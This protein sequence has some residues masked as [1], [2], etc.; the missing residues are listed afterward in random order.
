MNWRKT[1]RFGALV[2]QQARDEWTKTDKES[3]QDD[4]LLRFYVILRGKNSIGHNYK[5]EHLKIYL[6]TR[7]LK[8]VVRNEEG[9]IPILSKLVDIFNIEA[10]RG[11]YL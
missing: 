6:S 4:V 2:Q 7:I 8:R 11:N 10:F 1:D 5:S 9:K 3:R